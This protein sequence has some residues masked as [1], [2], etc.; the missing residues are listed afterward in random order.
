[1]RL[2]A[3][4]NMYPPHHLGGYEVV[5]QGTMDRARARGHPVRVVTTMHREVGV[6]E[7][8]EP[9]VHRELEWYWHDHDLR[10]PSLISA[11]SMELSRAG[12]HGDRFN[13]NPIS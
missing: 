9:D 12:F 10:D 5:W 1:M 13:W 8:D 4:G 3:F 2:L 6:C 11:A 7:A